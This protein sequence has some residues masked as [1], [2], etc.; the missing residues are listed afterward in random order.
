MQLDDTGA[1]HAP[2]AH[3]F[4]HADRSALAHDDRRDWWDLFDILSEAAPNGG[5]GLSWLIDRMTLTAGGAR[6]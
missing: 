2:H 5:H 1:P 4:H 6:T 3:A